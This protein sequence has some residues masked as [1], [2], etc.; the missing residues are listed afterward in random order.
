MIQQPTAPPANVRLDRIAS[1][2]TNDVQG[3]VVRSDK[4]P[5]SGARLLFVDAD[6]VKSRRTVDADATGQFN[7]KLGSGE[8]LVYIHG[9]DGQPV[10]QRKIEVN[11][12]EQNPLL[13]VKR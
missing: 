7:V 6:R 5:L 9:T 10:F 12:N 11:Q 3:K 2:S 4:Q 1:N 13:L 8:W